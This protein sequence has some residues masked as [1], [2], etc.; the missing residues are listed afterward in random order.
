M[1]EVFAGELCGTDGFR[2]PVAIK[3]ILP[4]LADQPAFQRLFVREA[5]LGALLD[6]PNIVA[7]LDFDRDE[8][9]RPYLIMERIQ[10]VDVHAL[11]VTGPVPL[12]A[13]VTIVASVLRALTHAHALCDAGQ[14]L[15][16]LHRDISPKN[17]MLAWSGTV[18]LVDFG[19][20]RPVTAARPSLVGTTHSLIGVGARGKVGYMSPEQV[21][22]VELDGRS[23]VFSAG[24]VFHELLTG[25]PLFADASPERTVELL[26]RKKVAAPNALDPR[27]P[28]GLSDVCMSM[29]ARDRNRRIASARAALAAVLEQS[30]GLDTSDGDLCALLTERFSARARENASW[31]GSF[32]SDRP[33]PQARSLVMT[34]APQS[35]TADAQAMAAHTRTM[36]GSRAPDMRPRTPLDRVQ[37]RAW[38]WI[39]G[40][41]VTAFVLIALAWLMTR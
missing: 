39:G 12:A 34:G 27:V 29:L 40:A 31:T 38:A 28:A 14:P 3:R 5:R 21:H 25:T 24:V 32:V 9:G 19:V 23:D 30:R 13:S 20:A 37:T 33:V 16:V 22:G 41:L 15:G 6:H 1:A 17:I 35:A 18:K 4:A 10:G 8:N 11:M 7:V 36:P 26:L 2:R